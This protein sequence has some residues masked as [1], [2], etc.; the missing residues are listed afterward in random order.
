[1]K[2][3]RISWEKAMWGISLQNLILLMKAIPDYDETSEEKMSDK[4]F[5]EM[6]GANRK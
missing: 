3:Y 2:Y 1:M 6:F 4:D 5:G